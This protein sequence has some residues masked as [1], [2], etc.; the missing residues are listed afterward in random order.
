LISRPINSESKIYF[1]Y[2]MVTMLMI[3]TLT[4]T[5][6]MMF[7]LKLFVLF[8]WSFPSPL[9]LRKEMKKFILEN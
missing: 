1:M 6:L 4:T 9:A 8:L 5:K 7:S 2:L 3:T